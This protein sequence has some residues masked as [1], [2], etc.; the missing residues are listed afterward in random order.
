[1][2]QLLGQENC[3]QNLCLRT[4]TLSCKRESFPEIDIMSALAVQSELHVIYRLLALE[5]HGDKNDIEE[6][7]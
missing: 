6:I 5:G 3:R 1:M 2:W 7:D 4:F